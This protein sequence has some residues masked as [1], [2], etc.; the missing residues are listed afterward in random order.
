MEM[1]ALIAHLSGGRVLARGSPELSMFHSCL[2]DGDP[3]AAA[4]IVTAAVAAAI[5]QA[6]VGKAV[7]KPNSL[8]GALEAPPRSFEVCR[9]QRLSPHA[10]IP[11]HGMPGGLSSCRA[12]RAYLGPHPGTIQLS[13]MCGTCERQDRIA[14]VLL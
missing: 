14:G 4:A 7:R 5:A 10:G 11:T 1:P 2:V 13:S 8:M 6:T 12:G 9:I 3:A